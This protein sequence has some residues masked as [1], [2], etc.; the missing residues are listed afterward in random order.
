LLGDDRVERED[1]AAAE[2]AEPRSRLASPPRP[3]HIQQYRQLYELTALWAHGWL[4]DAANPEP[5]EFL[6]RRGVTRQV[7]ERHMLGYALRDEQ[8]LVAFLSEHAPE[9]L[10]YAQEAGLLVT[11]RQGVLRMHWNLC[12][13]LIFP[14]LAEGA[15]TDLR[16]RLL[17]ADA[18]TRSLAGSPASRG[19]MFPF[20]WDAIGGADSVILTESGE[21]K[22][23]VPLAAHHDGMLS[24]PTIGFP[25]INGLP[26]DLGSRLRAKGVRCLIIAYDTQ[27][28]PLRDGVAVLA[29]EE[30][31]TLKHGRMLADSGLEVRVSRLPLSAAAR[32][33]PSPKTDLDSFLLEHGPRRLQ[34]QIDQARLLDVYAASLPRALLRA[35][36]LAPPNPYPTHR[37]R[38]RPIA[39]PTASAPVSPTSSPSKLITLEQARAEIRMLT[40]E[41]AQHGN[42]LLILAHPPGAGKGQNTTIGLKDYLHA[43]PDPGYIVWA[44]LRKGQIADQDGLSFVPLHGRHTG[45]CRKLPEAQELSHKGYGVRAGLCQRRCPHVNHCA[46]LRQFEQ[47]ADFFAAQPLLQATNWWRDAGVV[48]LDEFAP[49]QLARIVRLTSADLAAMARASKCPHAATLLGW[50]GQLLATTADRSLRGTLLY[51]ELDALAE[52]DGLD[53]A[54]TLQRAIDALPDPVR[55][56]SLPELPAHATLTDYQALPPGYLARLLSI[57]A[58]E[59][60]KRMGGLRFSSRIETCQGVLLLYLRLEHLIAQ[61]TRPEQPKIILDGTANQDL[62]KAIFPHTPLHL[63]RPTITGNV[64]VIQ[65]LGQDWAK[66]TLH[67]ARRDCWYDAIAAQRRPGRATLVVTTAACEADVRQALAQRGHSADLLRVGHY[68]GLRG[69]N[70]SKG[71]HVILAQVY[72]PNREEIIR[73]ARALFA[74]DA[75][76]LDQRMILVSCDSVG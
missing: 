62:L 9:L 27:P 41:H 10:P 37:A 63:E 6:A 31:W 46:Y 72:Q 13:A 3:E 20:G 54:E 11:D 34:Q 47:E 60:R 21:F 24:V 25:G 58:R 8:A 12:G 17:R 68:G 66:T 49:A 43:G 35:A 59:Q 73:T 5:L 39:R 51:Q 29:P 14:T 76:P 67:G 28:R 53:V 65:V 40:C 16:A 57:L 56:A 18:K 33:Q 26:P 1:D 42:G 69:S 38:P 52:A 22:T 71:Y 55:Q 70:A 44:G 64:Q 74:D 50:L 2:R 45:N 36:R 7:A 30:L 4:L 19:A 61:L 23:L 15:V 32:L 48:V 75:T